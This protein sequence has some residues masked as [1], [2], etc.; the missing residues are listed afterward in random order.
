MRKSTPE[1]MAMVRAREADLEVQAVAQAKAKRIGV[2]LQRMNQPGLAAQAAR[3]KTDKVKTIIL[4]E[5]ADNLGKAAAPEA[6]CRKGCNHC[7]HI[8]VAM[9]PNEAKVIAQETGAHLAHPRL[10]IQVDMTTHG[11]PCTFL[12]PQGC[13]IYDKRPYACR[14]YYVLEPDPALCE[15]VEGEVIRTMSYDVMDYNVALANAYGDFHSMK[16]ADIRAFFPK[17]LKR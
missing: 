11:E 2:R 16:F 13:A 6:P 5:L 8:P 7:C 14:I 9:T 12:T 10:S 3:A 4:R 1:H 17:G 15:L